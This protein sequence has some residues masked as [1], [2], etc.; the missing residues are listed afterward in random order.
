[1]RWLP[2][3]YALSLDAVEAEV[4]EY[5]LLGQRVR[6]DQWY[7][8]GICKWETDFEPMP[9]FHTRKL[10]IRREAS[11][12]GQLLP[13]RRSFGF[14]IRVGEGIKVLPLTKVNHGVTAKLGSAVTVRKTLHAIS[15]DRGTQPLRK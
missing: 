1:V 4:Y 6:A 9:F 11:G 2:R 5:Q 14:D 13:V 8:I 3:Q 10:I 15:A 12:Y 7:K